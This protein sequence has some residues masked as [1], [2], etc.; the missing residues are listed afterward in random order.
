[1][2]RK[3]L[4]V[5]VAAAFTAFSAQGFAQT[6]D[7]ND[8]SSTYSAG[9]SA[10]CDTMTGAEK[11]QCLS[12]EAAKTQNGVGT[13]SASDSASTAPAPSASDASTSSSSDAATTSSGGA[14]TG[15]DSTSKI[16]PDTPA[17]AGDASKQ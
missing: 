13:P 16:D 9:G 6:A 1:M 10:R 5:A 15:S 12:D 2:N 11:D 14:S 17:N 8:S 7:K 3:L 4:F